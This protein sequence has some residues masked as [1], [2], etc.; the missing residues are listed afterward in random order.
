MEPKDINFAAMP[1]T[2]INVV[3]RPADFFRGMSKTGGFLE[4]L[5]FAVIMGFIAGI[6]QVILN[7]LGL[8]PAAGY[9]H[10]GGMTSS[11]AAVIFMPIAMAIGSFI[12]AAILFIIWKLMGSQ[13]DYET[14]YRCGAY[15]AALLPITAIIG[16]IPYVGNII[17]TGIYVYFTVM[18]SI[19]VHN[20]PSQKSW[21]VFGIIGAVVVIMAIS[22]EYKA[23]HMSSEWEK[24][25]RA[26]EDMRKE[27]IDKSKDM[28]KS[29]DEMRRQAQEMAKQ[30]QQQA[31]D[32]KRQA[33]Q[34]R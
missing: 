28:Q 26:G 1:Q 7:I 23:R 34:N 33:E 31:E 5:V 15:M 6:I 30:L 18:A 9:G 11:L 2:A 19:H 25:R 22:A 3:T 32:A 14:A 10:S 27:Y 16:A 17:N 21:M 29:S 8:G 24:W 13:E 4:P 20:L 12:G